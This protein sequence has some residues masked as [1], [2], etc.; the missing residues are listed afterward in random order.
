MCQYI[1]IFPSWCHLFC[2]VRQSV[3]QQSTPTTCYN[4]C[5]SRLGWCSLAFKPP[6]FSSKHNGHCGQTVIFL[7]QKS[8]GHFSKKYNLCPHVQLQ[9]VVWIFLWRFWSS[10]FFLVE[11]PFG[12]CWYRTHFTVDIDT[13][14]L[15]PPA[16]SQGP[17][18]L[19]WDWFALF[20]PKYAHLL[21]TECV[22][23]LSR[24]MAA[25]SHGVY[26]CVLLFVQMIPSGVGKL[27]P[28]M[29]QTCGG[30]HFIFLRSWLIFYFFSHDVRQRGTEFEGRPWNTSTSP[31]D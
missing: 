31:I 25:W 9:T 11:R 6:P 27:L 5:S 24:M 12:L 2:E 16:S 18:L 19:F 23:F 30:T 21:D 22:S 17:L 3:L 7:F 28:K 4:P 15:F 13:L 8:W 1:H 10:G 26:T 29:N 14:Y 20:A